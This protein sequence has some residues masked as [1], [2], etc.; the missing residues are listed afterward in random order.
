MSFSEL[1]LKN[2]K[3]EMLNNC[4]ERNKCE[5][6]FDFDIDH[7]G[8]LIIVNRAHNDRNFNSNFELLCSKCKE[9]VMKYK[10]DC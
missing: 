7:Y 6:F 3:R 1:I 5:Y 9:I 10:Y 2:L 4:I 8:N